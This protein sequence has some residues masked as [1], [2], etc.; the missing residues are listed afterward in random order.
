MDWYYVYF[1]RIDFYTLHCPTPWSAAAINQRKLT[2]HLTIKIM[3]SYVDNND[4][5]TYNN[6]IKRRRRR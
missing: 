5:P 6:S 4:V 3:L 2:R 1:R